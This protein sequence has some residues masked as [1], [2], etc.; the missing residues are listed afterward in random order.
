MFSCEVFDNGDKLLRADYSIDCN[1]ATHQVT[2]PPYNCDSTLCSIL[3][4]AT[5]VACP[6][7]TRAT[8]FSH[9]SW[10]CCIP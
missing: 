6:P 10:S 4:I 3:Q 1:S 2:S 5:H 8:K 7:A 9:T